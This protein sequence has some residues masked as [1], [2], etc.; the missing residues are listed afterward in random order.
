MS[1]QPFRKKIEEIFAVNQ[2]YYIDFYQRDY[3][4]TK[5]HIVKLLEDLSY[6]FEL[7]YNAKLNPT[8]EN[9][10]K[11]DWYYLSAYVTN[12]YKGKTFIV[13]GQQRLASITLILIKLYHL[14]INYGLNDREELIKQYI[15]GIGIDGKKYWMGWG[16]REIVLKDLTENGKRT[17]ELSNDDGIS[18]KNLYNNYEIIDKML[19]SYLNNSH[20]FDSFLIYFLTKVFLIEIQI[21]KSKDVP[22]VFE[23]IND[24]GERLKPYE[25]LKGKLLGQLDKEEVDEYNQIWD[26]H[27]HKLQEID[28]KEVDNFFRFYFRSKFVE[29][30]GEYREFDGDYHKTLYLEKWHKKIQLKQ[31]IPMVKSF[32]KNELNC[33]ATLYL[34]VVKESKIEGSKLS[35][36]LLYNDLN[37]QDRQY[38]LILSS[39]S[40]NDSQEIEK[41][42]LV[43]KLFDKYYT[44]LQLTGSYDSNMFTESILSLN[45]KIREKSLEDIEKE[46]NKQLITDISDSKG[47][48]VEMAFNWNDFKDTNRN[49]GIRFIRYFFARIEHFIT[50]NCNIQNESYHNLVRNTGSVYGYHIEHILANNEENRELFG[51]EEVF[52]TERNK[53]GALTLLK[54]RDNLSSGKELYKKKL[55]T[56]SG[57]ANLVWTQTLREDFYHSNRD[58]I[59][60]MK[61]YNLNFQPHMDKFDKNI[62]DERQKLLFDIS[63]IIWN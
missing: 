46:F 13:D 30:A 2:P 53:L 55:E 56:Y 45:K 54:G 11:Y 59:D 38:L 47:V 52:H 42:R 26:N 57:K 7:E 19:G 14:A 32:V 44:I 20:K 51:N 29:T 22:M 12:N 37:D 27:I 50:E 41:I 49:L 1:I 58:F 28:E 9:I 5:E 24:R 6:R 17:K 15:Q 34:K 18:I 21:D 3:K 40:L 16:S 35:K 4:W 31:N 36:H 8:L 63:K 25:V 48:E 10:E 61:K 33:F 23:V 60:F 62:V 39:C 43:A